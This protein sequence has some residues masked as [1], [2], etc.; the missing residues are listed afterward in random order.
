MCMCVLDYIICITFKS[1]INFLSD[2]RQIN[3]HDQSPSLFLSDLIAIAG[4]AKKRVILDAA[5]LQV[6][7]CAI[8]SPDGRDS[9][10]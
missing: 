6:R 3:L 7:H 1:L 5:A 2:K 9:L 10:S 8:L 4:F